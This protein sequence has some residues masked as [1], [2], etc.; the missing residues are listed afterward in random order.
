[1]LRL[2]SSSLL[3]P[4]MQS[5]ENKNTFKMSHLVVWSSAKSQVWR[6]LGHKGLTKLIW[7]LIIDQ[8]HSM[9]TTMMILTCLKENLV[10]EIDWSGVGSWR[11]FQDLLHRLVCL[12]IIITILIYYCWQWRKICWLLVHLK[13]SIKIDGTDGSK[14]GHGVNHTT[15]T[16]PNA[17]HATTSTDHQSS[18]KQMILAVAVGCAVPLLPLKYFFWITFL[19]NH[20][21]L[22]VI[23]LMSPWEISIGIKLL[24]LEW[25][26]TRLLW[27]FSA[28]C[29][30]YSWNLHGNMLQEKYFV[31]FI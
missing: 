2:T 22:L 18:E 9:I 27:K 4:Q 29:L 26:K 5:P 24:I 13:E 30:L 23:H 14:K 8:L 15:K 11:V 21:V 17:A 12:T 3:Q 25:S 28:D 7:S 16:Q 6:R 10:K 31:C 19:G 1:M 20:R